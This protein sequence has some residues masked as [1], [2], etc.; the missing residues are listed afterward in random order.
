VTFTA[1]SLSAGTAATL[2]GYFAT[3]TTTRDLLGDS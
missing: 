3:V 2:H 1:E